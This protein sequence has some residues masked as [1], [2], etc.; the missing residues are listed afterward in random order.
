M[1]SSVQ[2]GDTPEPDV[3][4]RG[5]DQLGMT[6]GG[7]IAP[8]VVGRREMR[9]HFK[10]SQGMRTA[11]SLAAARACWQPKRPAASAAPST[12]G[13]SS[14]EFRYLHPLITSRLS[15]LLTF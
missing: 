13:F 12:C 4:G 1:T 5:I 2:S 10:T 15:K 9:A 7:P 11:G 14:V 6:R 3:A 8:A